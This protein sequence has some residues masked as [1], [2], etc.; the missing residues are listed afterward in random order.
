MP[1]AVRAGHLPSTLGQSVGL[2]R[3]L[4]HRSQEK[5][6]GEK[7]S[8]YMLQEWELVDKPRT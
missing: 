6:K 8:A 2:Q 5:C 1:L 3:G 7:T 4:A